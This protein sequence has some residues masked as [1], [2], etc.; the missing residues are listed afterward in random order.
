MEKYGVEDARVTC[1][2]GKYYINYSAVSWDSWGTALAVTED[3]V[4][5]EK[6]GMIFHPE[7]KDVAIFPEKVGGKYI[8]L[9]RPNNSGF[10]KASI[11]Y[12]ESPDLLHWGNYKVLIRPRDIKWESMKI[13][14]GAP[15]IKT[16]QG[17]L[18]VYHGKGDN[19]IYSLYC[20]LL[21]LEEPSKVL[22]RGREPLLTPTE[23]Y[24]TDG[25]FSNVVFSN[26]LVEKDGKVYIYYGAADESTCLAIT[27]VESLLNSF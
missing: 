18:V 14:G 21:D 16:D 1:I 2:D 26:G 25:F 4:H 13:G 23:S 3:F 15:P 27:D 12:S 7:N 6:K 17:W 9:H 22:K 19:S 5:L 11:W 8:A 10:G 24:E 20:L